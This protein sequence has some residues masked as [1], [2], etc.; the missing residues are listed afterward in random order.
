MKRSE[1]NAVIREAT[2]RFIRH[3]WTLPPNPRWDVTDFGLGDFARC[4]LVLV[5]LAEQPEYCEKLMYVRHRQVTPRHYHA[6]KKED[7]ICRWG[8]LAIEL[9]SDQPTVRLQVNNEWRDV[10]TDRL[11][12]LGA[13]ERVT[14]TRTV[15]HAFWADSEY[16][17]VG[18]VSTAN[19]DTNDNFFENKDI[20]RF[21]RIEE[22]EPA[23]LKLVSD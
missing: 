22:D 6:G 8:R 21:S 16:A 13:G 11:L 2:D 23:I 10:P 19:D 12:I 5:N 7:I 17:I 1:I 3:G 15:L 14:L 18:E 4:G 9:P 20:G